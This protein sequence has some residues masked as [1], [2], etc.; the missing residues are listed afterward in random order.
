[1]NKKELYLYCPQR[2]VYYPAGEKHKFTSEKEV[3]DT[4]AD[5][6]SIDFDESYTS[7]YEWLEE[8]KSDRH[9]LNEMLDYGEW[10][11]HDEQGNEYLLS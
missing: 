11:I 4:L 10:E 2:M 8:F 9:R 5:Y 7:I 3:L 6:H 1:M